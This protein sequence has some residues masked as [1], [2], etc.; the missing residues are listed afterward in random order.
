MS[1]NIGGARPGAG[2]KPGIPN[3]ASRELK[4]IAREY[5]PLAIR[6]LAEIA[7]S[8][9]APAKARV[10][11]S[12]A[13]LDRGHGRPTQMIEAAIDQAITVEIVRFGEGPATE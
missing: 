2:R 4:E 11:A 13:L 12:V 10:D 7:G 6:T 9:T 5:T 1:G 8:D 3:K